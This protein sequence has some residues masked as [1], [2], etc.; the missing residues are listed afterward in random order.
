MELQLEE[1]QQIVE[2]C[3]TDYLS[4]MSVDVATMEVVLLSIKQ[5]LVPRLASLRS[6]TVRALTPSIRP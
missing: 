4:E 2:G 3:D 5:P 6:Q 1:M